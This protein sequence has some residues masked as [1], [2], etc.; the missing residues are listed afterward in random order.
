MPSKTVDLN[1]S[2]TDDEGLTFGRTP[3][4]SKATVATGTVD[5]AGILTV[6]AVGAGE[7]TITVTASDGIN[8]PVTADV[9]V[10]VVATNAQPTT[11]GLSQVDK[12]ELQKSLYVSRGT[13]SVTV[14]VAVDAGD[15]SGGVKDSVEMLVS[16]IGDKAKTDDNWVTVTATKHP[17]APN[18]YIIATTPVE[19]IDGKKSYGMMT[20]VK[21]FPVDKFGARSA[22]ALTFKAM[23]NPIPKAT[24]TI[25]PRSE[26]IR[27]AAGTFTLNLNGNYSDI[28]ISKYFSDLDV[29]LP[30][31]IAATRTSAGTPIMEGDTS[32]TV[33]TDP[34]SLSMAVVQELNTNSLVKAAAVDPFTARAP[35][36]TDVNGA[37][38]ADADSI[39]KDD[40]RKDGQ[41][42][43][44]V[45]VY[46][47]ATDLGADGLIGGVTGV[48]EDTGKI[49]ANKDKAA[50][51]TGEFK[52][53]ITCS[54]PDG[55][56]VAERS[57][58]VTAS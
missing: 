3:T 36:A 37:I 58:A 13:I 20:P 25:I 48:N 56:A 34:A 31:T 18:K 8:N 16:E 38:T 19:D 24:F 14:T 42:L 29:M 35:I 46:A 12:M 22:N 32:C 17:T 41:M 5:S 43:A 21:I 39:G 55:E 27:N 51:K 23:I 45:R 54:D 53:T 26:L 47:E 30:A 40:L 33:T 28:I 7:A 11:R 15:A 50:K 2:I 44:A 4:S 57:V 52:I 9:P 6:R 49:V 1:K 10:M